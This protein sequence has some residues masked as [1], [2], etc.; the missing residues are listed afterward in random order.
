M[1]DDLIMKYT[2]GK[3]EKLKSKKL[4]EQLFLEG[5][6]VKLYP[7]QLIYLEKNHK[8]EF[9]IQ[10]GFS[11]PKRN[12]K[13]AVNRNRI[14]RVLREIYR[15]NKFGFSEKIGKKYIFMFIY[16][17]KEEINHANL[18]VSFLKLLEKF[19]TK[20]EGYEAQN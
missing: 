9:P 16:M 1:I 7:I 18:E 10:V 4:I 13:L 20:I 8:A 17:A 15:C 11:V 2:L 12:I 6:R 3:E 14:K 5:T 19:S